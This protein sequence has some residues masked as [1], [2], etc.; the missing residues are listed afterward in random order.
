V[1]APT[2]ITAFVGYTAR[3]RDNSAAT[4]VN[5]GDFERRFGGLASDSE[6][7]YAVRHFFDNGGSRAVIV[8]VPKSDAVAATIKVKGGTSNAAKESLI[9][10]AVSKGAWANNVIADVDHEGVAAKQFNLTLTDLATGDSER[11]SG[12]SIEKTSSSYAPVVIND[13][14][15]GSAFVAAT[16]PDDA[17]N[18]PVP[19]G[20]SGADFEFEAN[21]TIK[22]LKSDKDYAVKL[23]ASRPADKIKDLVV[24]LVV[25]GEAVPSSV[26]GLCRLLERRFNEAVGKA[27]AGAALRVVPSASGI[28][29]RL[30]ASFSPALI[31]DAQDTVLTVTNDVAGTVEMLKLTA[32]TVNV[33][34]YALGSTN[35]AQ[36]QNAGVKGADGVKLPGAADLLGNEAAF[37]GIHALEKTDIFNLMCLPD[38]TR[39]K[40]SDPS[41]LDDGLDVGAV[42]GGA[43]S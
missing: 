42:F 43:L 37:T 26:G 3:G 4:I 33:A 23:T 17:A 24:K 22:D 39:A 18:A 32:P 15:S 21:G 2:S 27:L 6:L 5:F 10:T 25:Q 13:P 8:R 41:A 40:A 34:H 11:F 38:A 14:S 20:T 36:A 1:G 31:A 30:I 7:S 19:T 16:V 28:G 35:A 9:L 29:L 12:L